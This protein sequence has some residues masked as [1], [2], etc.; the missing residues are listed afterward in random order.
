MSLAYH[1]QTDG[2]FERTILSLEDLLRTYVFDH[3]GSWDEILTLMEFTYNNSYHASI[4]MAPY[5]ALY[6]WWCMTP[7]CC[8]Q[9]GELIT[10]GSKLL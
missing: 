8:F 2:Q 7:L 10:V 4:R 6:S 9:D 1:P 3:L 5:E